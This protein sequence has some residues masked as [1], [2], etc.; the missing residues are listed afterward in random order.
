MICGSNLEFFDV[1]I[2]SE[3]TDNTDIF[4]SSNI[5]RYIDYH[6]IDGFLLAD[7]SYSQEKHLITPIKSPKTLLDHKYN[8]NFTNVYKFPKALELWNKRFLCLKT[9]LTNNQNIYEPIIYATAVLHNIGVKNK[10]FNN[11]GTTNLETEM[12]TNLEK[13]LS[14]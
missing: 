3:Q 8:K 12:K 13:I 11:I 14:S 7:S 5:K 9:S 1:Y 4:K 10:D 2:N 6:N